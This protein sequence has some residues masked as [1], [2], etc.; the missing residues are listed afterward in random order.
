MTKKGKNDLKEM[1]KLDKKEKSKIEGNNSQEKGLKKSKFSK[2]LILFSIISILFFFIG[3]A[4]ILTFVQAILFISAWLMETKRIKEPKNGVRIILAVLAFVLI[5]PIFAT[6]FGD[7]TAET[8]KWNNIVMGEI[9]PEPENKKGKILTNSDERLSIDIY[10]VSEENY[11]EYVEQCK[12]KGFTIDSKTG[13]D[14]YEAY[15]ESGYKLRIYY[16][17]YSKKYSISLDVPIQMKE[18]A[19]RDTLLSK[20]VPKPVSTLGKVET[21][22]ERYFTYYAGKTSQDD[23]LEYADK[24]FNAGFSKNYQK[25]DDYFYAIN[26]E[27]YKVTLTYKGNNIMEISITAPA[28]EKEEE[29]TATTPSIDETK[30]EETPKEEKTEADENAT[31]TNSGIRTD[32]KNAMDSYEEFMNEYVD[33]IKKYEANPTDMSLLSQYGTMM[34]KY[35]EQVSAFNQWESDDMTKEEVAYYIDV[36]ARVNKKLLEVS[37]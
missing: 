17:E 11:N 20:L 27:G 2:I 4:K 12:E 28:E 19:W 7:N 25:S 34:Q 23:F 3:S 26:P 9:L 16:S 10:K 1:I 15:N 5:I 36:Q 30:K 35:S 18:N 6:G 33:F 22:N 31:S 37:E 21:E 8:I 32:F 29:T 13:T 24:V 14:S